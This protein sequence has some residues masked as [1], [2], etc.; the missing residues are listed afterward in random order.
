M[1]GFYRAFSGISVDNEER[2]GLG[3]AIYRD[4]L[5]GNVFLADWQTPGIEN[6]AQVSL[7]S[8]SDSGDFVMLFYGKIIEYTEIWG[9]C[10]RILWR[11]YG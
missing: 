3:F 10:C 11:S 9:D 1:V 5:S 4:S 6:F 7:S 2:Y 8:F